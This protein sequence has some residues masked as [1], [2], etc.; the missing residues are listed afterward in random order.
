MRQ[1]TTSENET[2]AN[3]RASFGAFLEGRMSILSEFME[4]L[5]LP[6]PTMVLVEAENYL[7]ALDKWLTSQAIDK[8]DREWLLLRLGYFVGE[9]LVQ[10][11]GGAWFLNETPDTRYFSRY[12]VGRFSRVENGNAIADP[13]SVAADCIDSP[14][15]RSI[16]RLL[17]SVEKEITGA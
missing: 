17:E 2:I 5:E 14:P 3:R 13:L 15:G 8:S 9:Y 7:P 10:R 11:L 6:E 16:A 12:V 1:L 4:L